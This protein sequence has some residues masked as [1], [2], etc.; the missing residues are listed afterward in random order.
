M[1]LFRYNNINMKTF[2]IS[3]SYNVLRNG[4]TEICLQPS[5]PQIQRYLATYKEYNTEQEA[6]TNTANFITEQTPIQYHIFHYTESIPKEIRDEYT[7]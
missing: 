5:D 3:A 4:V 1:G 2:T 7:L 6:I